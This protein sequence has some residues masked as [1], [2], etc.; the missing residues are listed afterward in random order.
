M[1]DFKGHRFK[2]H[3][4]LF[5]V[6]WYLAYLLSYR[7]LE[8]MMTERG[9]HVVHTS[10]YLWVRKITPKLEANFRRVR[11]GPRAA[12]G[13]WTRPTSWSRDCIKY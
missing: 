13:G 1:I 4:I 12:I 5:Y 3:I 10:I 9:V 11:S 2:K 6:R 8:E 7:N